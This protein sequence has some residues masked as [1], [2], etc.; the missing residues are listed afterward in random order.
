MEYRLLTLQLQLGFIFFQEGAQAVGCIEEPNPLFV[1][2][3]HGEAAEPVH[4][5][6]ALLADAEI[7]FTGTAG[8]LLLLQLFKTGLQLLIGWFGHFEFLRYENNLH[9]IGIQGQY[10]EGTCHR[11]VLGPEG[12]IYPPRLL[13]RKAICLPDRQLKRLQSVHMRW[14]FSIIA[15]LVLLATG[16]AGDQPQNLPLLPCGEGTPGAPNCNPSKKELKE[17]KSE[18]ERGLKLQREKRSEESYAAFDKAAQLVPRSVD[19]LTARE[20]SRQQLVFEHMERGNAALLAGKQMDALAEFKS[21]LHLDPDNAF[22]QQRIQEVLRD[23]QPQLHAAPQIVNGSGE[24]RVSPRQVRADF[25]Y[26]GDSRSLLAQICAV[27][28][29]TPSLDDSVASRQVRFNIDQVDFDTAMRAAGDVT[30][31]FWSP[32]SSSQVLIAADTA[33]NHRQFDRMALRTFYI[34]GAATPQDLNEVV[35]LL[36]SVFEIRFVNPQPRASTIEVRAPQRVLDAAT[37]LIENLGDS[38]PQVLLDV[39]VFEVSHSLTRNIGVHIPNQFTLFNIPASALAALGGQNIQDLINQ[40]IAGGGIN[41]AN[42]A[43]LSALLAQLGNQQNSI[44]KQPV[45]T[46]G[47]GTT[48][49]GVTLDQLSAQ[50]SLNESWVRSLEHAT[51]R[52]SQGNEGN[53][54]IGTRY[55]ILNASFAPIFNTPA[56]AQNIQNNTFQPA[57]PSFSYEDLGL[58]LKAKPLINS[59]SL[60]SMQIDVQVRG[61]GTTTL[62]GVPII[63]NRQYTGSISLVNGEPAVIASAVSESE[64]LSLSGIPG[65]GQVPGLN[66]VMAT[67]SKQVTED[68]LLLVITPHVV[69]EPERNPTEV[70]LA[71]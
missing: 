41:Q 47:N 34:P 15:L 35:N 67:N 33:E 10:V 9:I 69:S 5:D 30:H 27:F 2:Q 55:P 44:F 61:L 66:R 22:A 6:S 43:A 20:M 8:S 4:A 16:F 21:A 46:F 31:T 24:I 14:G 29:I 11:Q 71:K 23:T 53:L 7:Q 57:F 51:L 52:V 17:A 36:R 39:K 58:T 54:H 65:L 3:S 25:H 56:I 60:V 13:L 62:N 26:S 12:K 40:L 38:R 32:L 18:Y 1:V 70:W 28:G 19:Y 50:L 45:A 63:T 68:E 59:D 64:Q 48:L 42:S 37:Q 49:F